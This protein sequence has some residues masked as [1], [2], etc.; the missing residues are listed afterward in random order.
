[1]GLQGYLAH[2]KTP[3]PQGPPQE[4]MQG[5][6]VGYYGLAVSYK[7]GTPVQGLIVN[8]DTHRPRVLRQG[9]AWEHRTTPQGYLAH[10]KQP[11]PLEP[12]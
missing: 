5:P 4:P 9:Y 6:T 10:K 11:P 7:R 12:P 1:M 8:M 3:P 2:K